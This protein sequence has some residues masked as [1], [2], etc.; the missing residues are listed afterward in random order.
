MADIDVNQILMQMRS[1]AAAAQGGTAAQP[2]AATQGADF[3]SLLQSS[4]NQ[5]NSAQKT[6]G[7]M[8]AAFAKGDP[9][10]D[11][12]E[13]MVAVQKSSVSFQAM[14]Q[15]RNK[16]VQAYQDVMNMPI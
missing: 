14:V 13:V 1:M 9:S 10:V 2:A 16:L 15:V 4:V 12:T 6:A 5:V 11:L 8:S 3:A 7:S